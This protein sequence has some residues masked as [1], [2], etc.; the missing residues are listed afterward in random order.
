MPASRLD[1]TANGVFII[2]ATPFTEDGALDLDSLDRLTD[3]YLEHGVTG[4]TLLG[5]MGEAHKLMPE[6]SLAVMR[7]VIARVPATVKV[8]VGV[9]H[10]GLPPLRALALEAM[11]IGAAGVMVAPP[12]GTKGDDGVYG[13]YEG[14][15]R[16]LGAEVP[17]VLQDYPQATAVHLSVRT[18]H[19]LVD[20][21]PQLVML[22][23]EDCP[24]LAK[25]GRIRAEAAAE[26]RRRVSILI[27]NGGLYYPQEMMRGADGAMTGFAYPEMLV[28]VHR[29][30]AAGEV[31]A[32]E[33]LFDAYL[34]LVR[35]EQQPG[36]GLAIRKE[37]LVRRGAIAC[38]RQ[39]APAA[40]LTASDLA[41]LD[42][43]TRRLERRLAGGLARAAE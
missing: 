32:A 31:D 40:S 27:G 42:H 36:I 9:S 19:R 29:L 11:E 12:Q 20:A 34:P 39:R 18:F 5:I 43:L 30:F 24:G 17:V 3:F 8:I 7:R 21:F 35:Y 14:V 26:K 16:A 13:Y 6:E 38:A 28:G 37:I 22:K 41:E 4:I 23:H 25:L 1:E 15:F 10:A 33:D 2:S